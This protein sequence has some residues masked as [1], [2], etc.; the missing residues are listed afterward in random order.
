MKK[1]LFACLLLFVLSCSSDS[2]TGQDAIDLVT[3]VTFRQTPEDLPMELG[4]PNVW[5]NNQ[6]ILYPN[7]VK[8]HLLL[9]SQT[10]ISDIWIIPA[11]AQKIYQSVDYSTVLTTTTYSEAAVA[12]HASI[13]I[14]A[15]TS[16]VVDVNVESL[17]EGYY[18]V[19]VKIDGVLYWDN[20]YVDPVN[21]EEHIAEVIGFWN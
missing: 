4:N 8:Q 17:T 5:V 11:H 2:S 1:I 15:L 19:F 10:P 16:T 20:V 7:P 21:T 6:F 12:D 9:V 18:R 14:D 3:G 13:S